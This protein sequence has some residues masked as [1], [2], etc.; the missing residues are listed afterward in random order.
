MNTQQA[1]EKLDRYVRARY[2]MI[3]VVS[4][5]ESRVITAVKALATKRQQQVAEWAI[6]RLCR[7]MPAL[8]GGSLNSAHSGFDGITPDLHPILGAAGP[9]GFYLDCGYS[10]TGFKTAPA[11]GL[12]LAELILDGQARTVDISAL[13]PGR[14][15][16]GKEVKEN[17]QNIW[18]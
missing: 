15:A 13:R 7:R 9:D 2:P 16:E 18:R 8:D 4:H 6:E 11:V 3:A 17:Y 14:F 12:C 10:G 1:I 5:E